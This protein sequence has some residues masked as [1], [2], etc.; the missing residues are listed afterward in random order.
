MYNIKLSYLVTRT[1]NPTPNPKTWIQSHTPSCTKTSH[2]EARAYHRTD[3]T[4]ENT[5]SKYTIP[6]WVLQVQNYVTIITIPEAVPS[7]PLHLCLSDHLFNHLHI[8]LLWYCGPTLTSFQAL[9]FFLRCSNVSLYWSSISRSCRNIC[10]FY[11]L[12]LF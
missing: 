2:R 1:H 5:T 4:Q 9:F 3:K 11:L 7:N 12:Q 6:F 10:K 8:F